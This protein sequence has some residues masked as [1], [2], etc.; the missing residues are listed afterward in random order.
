MSSILYQVIISP[1]HL[2]CTFKIIKD[3]YDGD[4]NYNDNDDDDDGD[5]GDD[6][7]DDG[8]DDGGG[9]DDAEN[10]NYVHIFRLK[11]F[12]LQLINFLYEWGEH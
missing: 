10:H 6:D 7:D 2:L 4:D 8:D 9:G 1:S 3:I 5:G 11:G 12:T